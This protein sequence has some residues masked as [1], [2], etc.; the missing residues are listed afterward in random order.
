MQLLAAAI[1]SAIGAIGGSI[2]TGFAQ[3]KA[4]DRGEKASRQIYQTEL[5]ESRAERISSEKLSRAQLAEQKRQFNVSAGIQ[6][7]ALGLE[8]QGMASDAFHNQVSRLTQIL[9]KN[10]NLKNLYV[11][12]VNGLRGRV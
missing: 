4:L 6:K 3:K 7:Q 8:L 5:A 2:A 9:N 1:I 10:E 11:G 12:R